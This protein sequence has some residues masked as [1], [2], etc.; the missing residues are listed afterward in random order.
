MLRVHTWK[1][2]EKADVWL[3][4]ATC[5]Q[6]IW[7]SE[8]TTVLEDCQGYKTGEH[9]SLLMLTVAR[10]SGGRRSRGTK[11]LDTL[12]LADL[13][14]YI[15][16]SNSFWILEGKYGLELVHIILHISYHVTLR[17]HLILSAIPC[18]PSSLLPGMPSPKPPTFRQRL[19]ERMVSTMALAW[20]QRLGVEGWHL[21]SNC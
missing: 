15:F 12:Q 2:H 10:P 4:W 8:Q 21:P 20:S 3:R 9:S 7:S 6:I 17:F 14:K 1:T 11:I 18:G 16:G 5:G 13:Y 19:V